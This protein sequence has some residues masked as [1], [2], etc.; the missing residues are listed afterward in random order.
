[1]LVGEALHLAQLDQ[2]S[3][4]DRKLGPVVEVSSPEAERA[5][6][7]THVLQRPYILRTYVEP[8]QLI[9]PRW[10]ALQGLF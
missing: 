3:V 2:G 8:P 5:V 4:H 6:L 9:K 7:Q 1:M 10:R